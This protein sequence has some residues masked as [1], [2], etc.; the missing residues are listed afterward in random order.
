MSH[1]FLDAT[2]WPCSVLDGRPGQ[3]EQSHLPKIESSDRRLSQSVWKG[4]NTFVGSR[5][6]CVQYFVD[7]Q[8]RSKLNLPRPERGSSIFFS[9][10]RSRFRFARSPRALRQPPLYYYYYYYYYVHSQDM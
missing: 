6:S 10:V 9:A 7:S 4:E 8:W 2:Q 5:V 3:R 1:C